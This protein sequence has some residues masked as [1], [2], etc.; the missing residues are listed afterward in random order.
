MPKIVLRFDN[1]DS[2]NAKMEVD[3]ELASSA[4]SYLAVAGH[5]LISGQ[6][7]KIED[8]AES[9]VI[10]VVPKPGEYELEVRVGKLSG[11]KTQLVMLGYFLLSSAFANWLGIN[12]LHQAMNAV[13]QSLPRTQQPPGP[14][15][16]I[17]G[18]RFPKGN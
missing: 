6:T 8:A 17:P 18:M 3:K 16:I 13:M 15:I 14:G 12:H 2:M 7:K 9:S 4:P 11:E 1:P 5:R 10:I